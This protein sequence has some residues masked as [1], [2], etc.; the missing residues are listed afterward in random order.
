MKCKSWS[1]DCQL[2]YDMDG[3]NICVKYVSN[4]NI[5]PTQNLT[6]A[7]VIWMWLFVLHREDTGGPRVCVWWHCVCL[8]ERTLEDHVSVFDDIVFVWQR[9]H[10]R[11]MSLCLMT[12]C[13]CY[14]ERTLEDHES[15]FDV[16]HSWSGAEKNRLY[17]R[18]D[19]RKYDFF[20]H[21]TVS[22][23]R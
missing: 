13:L 21:P 2:S 8:T 1:N 16:Y 3:Q 10:W 17:F 22:L 23:I 15:V 5:S 7:P 4:L 19:F 6:H 9:E 20:K 18:K 11:T 12:F 14:T